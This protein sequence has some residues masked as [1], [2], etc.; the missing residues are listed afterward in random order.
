MSFQSRWLM[1]TRKS[2]VRSLFI[3]GNFE[4][5]LICAPLGFAQHL[6]TDGGEIL[7][8]V[9]RQP[10]FALERREFVIERRIVVEGKFF[11]LRFEEEIER[12]QHRH[13]GDQIHLHAEFA[14][15]LV[16]DEPRGVIRLRVLHPVDE[17]LFR[18]DAERIAQNPRARMRR[19]PQPDDL[20]AEIDQP[21]VLVMGLVVERDVNGHSDLRL[22]IYDSGGLL[23]HSHHR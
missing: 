7:R 3:F 16:K 19:G 9:R 12:I 23:F 22:T 21:V 11:R 1:A 14:R 17:M 20:R 15:G 2:F 4:P 13:L 18:R 8:E 6:A 5:F 10:A